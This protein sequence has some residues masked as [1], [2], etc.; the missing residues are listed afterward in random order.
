[1]SPGAGIEHIGVMRKRY[2]TEERERLI[3]EVRSTGEP[4]RVVAERLGICVSSAFRWTKD[5][6]A[7]PRAPTFARVLPSTAAA[8]AALRLEVGRVTVRVDTGFD[9]DLL[10][11][12]VAA[13]SEPS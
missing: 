7:V 10:R 5:A 4:V 9:P 2:T 12:V 3:E 1:M 8:S 6:R 13:L 11:R